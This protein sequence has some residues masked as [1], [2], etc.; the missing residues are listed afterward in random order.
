MA[1][2]HA[3]MVRSSPLVA[4][5]DDQQKDIIANLVT[6]RSLDDEE[7]L[8]REG[9]VS[10][11]L[12]VIAAGSLAVTRDTGNAEWVVVHLLRTR[13]MAGELGFLDSLE[14]SATL[15][16]VGPTQIFSLRRDR[17]EELI[18]TQPM[19]VY[20]VMRAIVREVHGILRR[21]NVQY[22]E[23]TN[24]IAKQHGRY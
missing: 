23:M 13:D 6:W 8:I 2:N 5:M 12:H 24:Y 7:V 18:G 1:I 4:E 14:H 11:E 15:R 3:E 19:I 10:N 9:E 22:V 20:L 17:L 16:A 21:M